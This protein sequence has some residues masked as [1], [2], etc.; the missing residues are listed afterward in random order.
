MQ[1]STRSAG[2]SRATPSG[3]WQAPLTAWRFAGAFSGPAGFDRWRAAL[4]AAV[5]YDRFAVLQE[6]ASDDEVIH[7]IDAAGHA[8]AT[9]RAYASQVVRIFTV[10]DGRIV[11]GRTYY[12]TAAYV[13]AL[14][15]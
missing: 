3:G 15:V 14:G 4:N 9:G 11:G 6:L 1:R 12:D 7:I 10:R 13:S 8:V 2:S 5:K